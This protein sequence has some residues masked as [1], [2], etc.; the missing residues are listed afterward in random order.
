MYARIM[1]A[2]VDQ[3]KVDDAA[4]AWKSLVLPDHRRRHGFRED[5]VMYSLLAEDLGR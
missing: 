1:T 5:L 2:K 4:R 3:R